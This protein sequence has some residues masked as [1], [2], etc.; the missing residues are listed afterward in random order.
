M[1]NVFLSKEQRC[2]TNDNVYVLTFAC[3]DKSYLRI[4]YVIA[5]FISAKGSINKIQRSPLGKIKLD[6]V[7]FCIL[8]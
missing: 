6:I 8:M 7:D 5:I 3:F 2:Q 4:R 1:K